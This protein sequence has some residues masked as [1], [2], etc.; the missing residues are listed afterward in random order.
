[1]SLMYKITAILMFAVVSVCLVQAQ[2][3]TGTIIGVVQDASGRAIPNAAVTLTHTATGQ[4]R[5]THTNSQGAFNAQF[6]PLGTYSISALAPGFQKKVLTGIVLQVD[7]TANLTIALAVGSVSQSVEVTSEAPLVDTTTS[8][9]GQVIDNHEILSMPLNGRNAFAL[10][11]LV[12]NTD[13]VQGMGTNLPF[14]GGSGRF[15]SGDVSLNGIDDN[16]FATAGAIGRQGYAIVPSVD[17][18]EEFKV[19]T[20]NYSAEFGH[21]A[22]T[23]V[24]ATL[25][26]G[27]NQFHGVAF[28]FVRNDI[29]DANNFFTNRAGLPR[30]PFHQNQYGGTLGG[31]ILHNRIFFFG[32]Y[33]GT[34]ITTKSGDSVES[35]PPMAWRT[36]D[37]SSSPTVLYDPTTRHVGPNGTVIATSFL[38]ETG[39]NKI[40]ASLVNPTATAILGLIPAPNYGSADATSN[41]F[42]YA[43]TKSSNTDQGDLRIDATITDKNHLT[44]TYSI[45]NNYQPA[46]GS[47]PGWIGG[48]TAA[49]DNNDQ[50]TLSDVHIF[51]AHLINE[52]RI[53][54]LYNNGT[55]PGGGPQG[56]TFAKGIGLAL[57]PSTPLQ[58]P[59]ISLKYSGSAANGSVEFTGFGGA[60]LNLNTLQT[61]QLADSMS[62]TYGQHSLK[63]GVDIRNSI[64][65]VLKGGPSSVYGSIFSSSSD[66]PNSGLPLAD[67]LMGFPANTSSIAMIAKGRQ[68]TA[69]FGGYIQDDWKTTSK[70]TLDMGLRYELYTQPIDANN[71][72]SLFDVKTGQF[73]IPGQK[74]YSRAMVYGDHNDWGPRLGFAYEPFRKW[75]VRG[76]YGIFYAMRD[77][78]QQTT[79]FSGNTPNIPTIV[80]P[81]ITAAHTVS[82]PYTMNTPIQ[83]VPATDSLAGFT[84]AKPYSGQIKSQSIQNGLMPRLMQYNLDV[85]YQLNPTLLFE[86][87]YS[88]ARG[89]H[90][91]SFFIDEN[92]EPFSDAL[93]GTNTQANRPFPYMGS[94]VLEVND[95]STQNYNALNLKAQEQLTHG[96]QFLANYTWQKNLESNGDGPDSYSQT[97][98]SVALYT[99]DLSREKGVAPLNIAQ[100]ASASVLYDLPFGQGQEFLNKSG[101]LNYLFGGWVVNG[102]LSMRT[103][104]PTDINTNVI[105]PTFQTYN[106]A[107]CVAGVPKKLPNAGVDGYFNPAAF[108]VPL[109]ATS[110]TGAK[111]TEFGNCGHFPVT[112]PGSK[113]FDSS[114][115]K[116]FNLSESHRIYL[117]FRAEAFN[118][119]NTPTFELPDASNVTLTCEG[120]P[121]AI[122]NSTNPN[123]G[124]LVNGS[125]T[126]RQL[127]FAAKLYF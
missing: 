43:P 21:A 92:Q 59:A 75:V 95:I 1:M 64:F 125:A 107:S 50:I 106:V 104:F 19:L 126:G 65:N 10:G 29:F 54:Y 116:N 44:G 6:M 45:S 60:S 97:A 61:R 66:A 100:T 91:A 115:F 40:P 93:N 28:E 81:T 101:P 74:P 46:V 9:L 105:P 34:R 5:Q 42:F 122:C 77:Q 20:N 89:S 62:W 114:L 127:Q 83:T 12:G 57:V 23:I 121:G 112:G 108:T 22:G 24:A 32:D 87:S 90:F 76:G 110:V 58:F 17:A 39:A 7:Q 14:A 36:G 78:N 38:A 15:S 53:G 11:L 102:I 35:V 82:P 85:Q 88:G 4:V 123:F 16:T 71:L 63:W 80:V 86:A 68:H 51:S 79:Q 119:T 113:N 69:Y 117:Q 67:F 26:A 98:T 120:A 103:G 111:V 52:L 84:A 94:S 27:T 70:L 124:K 73:A 41:N 72:G 109:D 30:T 96:L 118:T 31:P 18:V 47:F 37:F 8:S 55:Q 3:E 49:L 33:Q 56:A 99:Y 2:I 13:P 48:G 25:K